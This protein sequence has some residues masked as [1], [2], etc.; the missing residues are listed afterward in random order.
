MNYGLL[1]KA[2]RNE[3]SSRFGGEVAHL[4]RAE[5]DL[6]EALGGAGTINPVTGLPEYYGVA[7]ASAPPG[8]SPAAA[9]AALGA[10]GVAAGMGPGGIGMGAA[11]GATTGQGRGLTVSPSKG[12]SG[13]GF[14]VSPA[15][16][17][18]A[19]PAPTAQAA[20]SSDGDAPPVIPETAYYPEDRPDW[21]P[22][23]E[24][25][26]EAVRPSY[27]PIQNTVAD[28]I[29]NVFDNPALAN[30][31]ADAPLGILGMLQKGIQQSVFLPNLSHFNSSQT[32]LSPLAPYAG[33]GG[34]AGVGTG[35][36]TKERQQEEGIAEEGTR[37]YTDTF[38]QPEATGLV[39][40]PPPFADVA[41]SPSQEQLY[42][43]SIA[44]NEEWW[45]NFY[46]FY[47][48]EASTGLI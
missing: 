33:P 39:A 46:N 3:D 20:E 43:Q 45:D 32:S 30:T 41:I 2:G 34:V 47:G 29:A 6:L 14:T 26:T 31:F 16:S 15:V 9:N 18:H 37:G 23:V 19:P 5:A 36:L 38:V 22:P 25:Q 4:S 11:A 27:Q 13:M 8:V 12:D 28:V 48:P 40:Q 10:L 7:T 44:S 1:A 24:K 35:G 42:S 17:A 21:N